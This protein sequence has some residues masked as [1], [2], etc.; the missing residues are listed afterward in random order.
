MKNSTNSNICFSE[1][2][3]PSTCNFEFSMNN[4]NDNH[5]KVR[6]GWFDLKE[7][8]P[9]LQEQKIYDIVIHSKSLNEHYVYLI[10][11]RFTA[12]LLLRV[13][14][15]E[16]QF[17]DLSELSET[18]EQEVKGRIVLDTIRLKT[19]AMLARCDLEFAHMLNEIA[20]M[21][22]DQHRAKSELSNENRI[23]LH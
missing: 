15:S 18:E 12:S 8:T 17:G 10:D 19:I 1:I 3:I 20:K 5:Y 4:G 11:D 14:V 23:I 21:V 16:S 9:K 7:E 2:N 6:F 13:Y 22:D